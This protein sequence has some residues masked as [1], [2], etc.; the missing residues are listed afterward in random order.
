MGREIVSKQD[1][2]ALIEKILDEAM[3]AAKTAVKPFPI[4]AKMLSNIRNAV[5]P[6]LERNI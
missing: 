6:V 2:A 1:K 3:E 4:P 5:K